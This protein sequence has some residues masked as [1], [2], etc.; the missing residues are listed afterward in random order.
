MITTTGIRMKN[1]K[2][3]LAVL[4]ILFTISLIYRILHPYKQQRV[5]SLTHTNKKKIVKVKKNTNIS[6]TRGLTA[7]QDIM[8]NLFLSPPV[9]SGSMHRNI[10]FQ[11]KQ[12]KNKTFQQQELQVPEKSTNDIHDIINSDIK[13]FTVFGSYENANEK[14]V[15]FKR[16][17]DIIVVRKGDKIDDKYLIENISEHA[18]TVSIENVEEKIYIDLSEL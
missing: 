9:H 10:F 3:I 17:K 13:N 8:L 11:Q 5:A 6:E 12:I 2:I 14:V 15:F 16:G 7:K 1:K 18:V 4:I